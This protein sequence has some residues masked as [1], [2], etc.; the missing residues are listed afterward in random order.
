MFLQGE[1]T[2]SCIDWEQT[3]PGSVQTPE[4][5]HPPL[6]SFVYISEVKH[7]HQTLNSMVAEISTGFHFHRI[8]STQQKACIQL[9]FN[10]YLL[11]RWLPDEWIPLK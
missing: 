3:L 11:N 5:P 7:H 9:A 6:P 8:L 1:P 2:S 4:A 10:I